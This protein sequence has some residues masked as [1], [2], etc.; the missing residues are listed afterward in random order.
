MA[1]PH[2]SPFHSFFAKMEIAIEMDVA[3][4]QAS[5]PAIEK[6]QMLPRLWAVIHNCKFSLQLDLIRC[7]VLASLK[8]WLEPLPDGSLP[9]EQVRSMVLQILVICSINLK[10]DAVIQKLKASRLGKAI[11]FL[12]NFPVETNTNQKLT[13]ELVNK[14]SRK[15]FGIS[16]NF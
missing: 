2:T 16:D 15:I 1:H 6:L 7:G 5:K 8:K 4:N 3:L 9:N 12:G 10:N 11:R 13:G 14:W